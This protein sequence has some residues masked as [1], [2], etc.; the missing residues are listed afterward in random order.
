MKRVSSSA[1]IKKE[2]AKIGAW[3]KQWELVL[4]ASHCRDPIY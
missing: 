2:N 3:N 4:V 1:V